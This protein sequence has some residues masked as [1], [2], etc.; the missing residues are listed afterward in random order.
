[1][2]EL[3]PLP[4]GRITIIFTDIENS[5]RMTA[6]LGD[7]VYRRAVGEP[8]GACLRAAIQEN[9]G[10]EVKTIGDSFMIAFPEGG[11]DQALACVHSIQ[12]RLAEKPITAKDSTGNTWEVRVRIGVHKADREPQLH[13]EGNR[14]DYTG[15]DVNF[16][17]RVESLGAGG[18]VIVSDSAHKAGNH[19]LYTWKEWPRRRIKS[20]DKPE[21]VWELL[22]DG[23]SRGEPGV[24]WLPDS[25]M[26]ERNRY[27]SRPMVEA[28]VL[29]LFTSPRPD[30]QMPRLVTIC[31]FGGMG[32]TRLAVAC[33]IQAVGLVDGVFFARL[34][35]SLPSP[36]SVAEEIRKA[37]GWDDG[38][39]QPHMI[40]RAMRE[41]NCLLVLDNYE[42][43]ESQE[44][45]EFIRQLVIETRHLRLLVTGREAVKLHD[46]EHLVDL[47]DPSNQMTAE[48]CA[49]LFVERARQKRG[50]GWKPN[51]RDAGV[52][53]R[54]VELAGHI[55]LAIELAAAWTKHQTLEEIASGLAATPLGSAMADPPDHGRAPGADRHSSLTRCLDWSYDLLEPECQEAFARLGI[56]TASF[57]AQT[58]SKVCDLPAA[59]DMLYRLQDASLAQRVELAGYTRYRM[60]RF[61]ASY[62]AGKL[63]KLP[64]VNTIRA[65][66]VAHY[67]AL[68]DTVYGS[69]D[70]GIAAQ[71]ADWENVHPLGA[72][73]RFED[74]GV[75]FI[76]SR[77]H[78]DF[79]TLRG[80]WL[81]K[82]LADRSNLAP[83]RLALE[84]AAVARERR[85]V[86]ET[87]VAFL[88]EILNRV[89]EGKTLDGV[90]TACRLEWARKAAFTWERARK[91]LCL[92]YFFKWQQF[93][94]QWPVLLDEPAAL[95]QVREAL[96]VL[97]PSEDD[98]S[99]TRAREFSTNWVRREEW[100]A[101]LEAITAW[102]NS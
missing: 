35:G 102:M 38:T 82:V 43:V 51:Q 42:K 5:S 54:I 91:R 24:S 12:K 34:E 59:Q 29:S 83:A 85:E 73:R 67:R 60:N 39:G 45:R 57:N 52:I 8:H 1:M 66:F 14:W 76:L 86:E 84:T 98:A 20:F 99:K 88:Q 101:E 53:G 3:C 15:S 47:D 58:A 80:L 21:T 7:A 13:R 94:F 36:E 71:E 18:Q 30:S 61:T 10:S 96:R 74:L 65:S 93:P 33:A 37:L 92:E 95:T 78:A 2:S 41:R 11:V 70:A 64:I 90:P 46:V 62:S 26:G 16:A 89:Q 75:I 22:W 100:V 63:V 6:A 49:E 9:A 23:H 69:D 48:E 19:E 32:K 56:F 28:K 31:G 55:P 4:S 87:Y 40:L 44:V 27:I 97:E 68:I 25:F 50:Q 77:C 81:S 79:W 17:N 72:D